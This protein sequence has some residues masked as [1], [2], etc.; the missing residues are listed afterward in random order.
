MEVAVTRAREGEDLHPG[1]QGDLVDS[2][3]GVGQAG[4]RDRDVLDE[5]ASEALDRGQCEPHLQQWFG[6]RPV[7]RIG[8]R[9]EYCCG[10]ACC[11]A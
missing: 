3:H 1:A 4:A 7:G 11:E 10:S 6:G 8:D 5:D 2:G 9:V